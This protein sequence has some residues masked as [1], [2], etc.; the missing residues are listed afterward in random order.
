MVIS[1]RVLGALVASIAFLVLAG[2]AGAA[3]IV[4]RN[5]LE[6]SLVKRINAV[7]KHHG[8]KPLRVA[9]ALTRSASRHGNSMGKV[10]YFRHE[11]LYK[12]NWKPFGTWISWYWPGEQATSWSAGENL[13]WGAPGLGVRK[14]VR[15][16]MHSSEHRANILEPSWRR[17]GVSIVHV[18]DPLG[19]YSDYDE[20]T[21]V[22]AD[23]GRR[24]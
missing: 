11:L 6:P 17:I 16:W 14:A 24:S 21:I 9:T 2:P 10:G 1:M 5:A 13:V 18:S 12:G 23:F 20:A 8:L 22:T 3:T 7:R 19:E 15:K 4:Q